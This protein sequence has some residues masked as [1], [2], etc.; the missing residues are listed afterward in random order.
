MLQPII[1]AYAA[2]AVIVYATA[3]AISALFQA[4]CARLYFAAARQVAATLAATD[5]WIVRVLRLAA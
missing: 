1:D 3:I 4:Y 5:P 2:M